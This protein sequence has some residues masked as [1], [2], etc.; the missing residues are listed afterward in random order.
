M[1]SSGLTFFINICIIALT[2]TRASSDLKEKNMVG[3]YLASSLAAVIMFIAKDA[4]LVKPI[5]EFFE[6]AY[7]LHISIALVFILFF[8]HLLRIGNIYLKQ[9]IELTKERLKK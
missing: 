9:L 7:V 5:F 2:A 6:A 8:A 3:F 1:F 4:K